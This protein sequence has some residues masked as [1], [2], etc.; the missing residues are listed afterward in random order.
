VRIMFRSTQGRGARVPPAHR[1]EPFSTHFVS[2]G[3]SLVGRV[4]LLMRG[5]VHFI[6]VM[7]N[8]FSRERSGITEKRAALASCITLFKS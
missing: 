2:G 1:A 6:N 7:Y 3:V 8:L 5:S 4:S